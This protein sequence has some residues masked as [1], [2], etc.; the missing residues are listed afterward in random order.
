L[1]NERRQLVLIGSV[2]VLVFISVVAVPTRPL[3]PAELG[4]AA[5]LVIV[6]AARSARGRLLATFVPSSDWS[7]LHS[8]S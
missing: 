5:G 7:R 8:S 4:A 2:A 1:P 6:L 3:D